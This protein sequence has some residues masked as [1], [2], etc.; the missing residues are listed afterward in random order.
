MFKKLFPLIKEIKS[1]T[2]EIHFRRWRIFETPWLR[3]YVHQIL[4]ADEDMFE[5]THPWNLATLILRG[6][7]V[8]FSQGAITLRR[9]GHFAYRKHDVPHKI[10]AVNQPTW[11]LALAIGSRK[12]WGY[13]MSEGV[14]IDNE[15]Y[16]LFKTKQIK[17]IDAQNS[18]N[19]LKK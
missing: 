7:Y 15:S 3:L 8:E 6:S 11:T 18:I 1:K 19:C 14:I 4:K 10:G 16:R 2:G 5:H 9:P 12:K 13:K 17:I